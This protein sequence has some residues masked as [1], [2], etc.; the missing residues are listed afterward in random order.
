[1]TE[2]WPRAWR[3]DGGDAANRPPAKAG[4]HS[5]KRGREIRGEAKIQAIDRP[6]DRAQPLGTRDSG[7]VA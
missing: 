2:T 7:D 6:L 1:M 5:R 4:E 3:R